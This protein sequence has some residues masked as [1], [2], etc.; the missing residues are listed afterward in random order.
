MADVEQ[1]THDNNNGAGVAPVAA[2]LRALASAMTERLA[3]ARVLGAT[4]GGKRD[5]YGVLGY[6][7]TITTMQYRARYERG[8][9][10]KTAVDAMPTAVWRGNGEIFEDEDPDNETEFEKQWKALNDQHHVWSTLQRAHVLASL[11]RFSAILIGTPGS[12][13][14]PLPKGQPGTVLY[15]RPIGGNIDNS[16]PSNNTRTSVNSA[17]DASITVKKYDEDP[18]SRR[19]GLPLNYSL[20]GAAFSESV[21]SLSVHYTR[22]VHIPSRGFLDNE[23]F[24]PPVLEA[25]WNYLLD[26]EKVEGG[27][28]EAFWLRANKIRQIDVDKKMTLNPDSKQADAELTALREQIELLDHQ[29]SRTIRTRGVNINDLGSDV[30]DFSGPQ[31]AILSLIAGTLRIPQRVLIGSEAGSMASD[32]DRDNWND[33]VSDCRTDYAHP[34]VLRPF[35]NRLIE[36]NYLPTPAQW[37]PEWP[38]EGA[39]TIVETFDAAAKLAEVNN[40]MGEIVVTQN[41]VREF[42]NY[43]PFTDAELQQMKEDKADEAAAA[44][45]RMQGDET[46]D[47]L[48]AAI[49]NG[50]TLTFAV[51]AS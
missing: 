17:P 12:L 4:H 3:L 22:I 40:K 39:M 8:G 38:D 21:R 47:K 9:I 50:G 2:E 19:F 10:A 43:E 18:R 27:G 1:P 7:D 37:E 42:L 28:A 46:V 36:F 25:V 51:G 11:N 23:L 29:L 32:Q 33:Q 5:I 13:E 31:G 48:E 49:R 45:E 44:T 34:I 6:D 16:S 14:A 35:I 41:E 20:L 26:L 30:A 24:G 15:L